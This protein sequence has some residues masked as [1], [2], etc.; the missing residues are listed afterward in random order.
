MVQKL[1]YD[2]FSI[3][4][5]DKNSY[6]IPNS[7]RMLLQNMNKKIKNLGGSE[8]LSCD[9]NSKKKRKSFNKMRF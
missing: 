4:S 5:Y 6:Y 7:I 2:N 1:E 3:K 8:N 9:A